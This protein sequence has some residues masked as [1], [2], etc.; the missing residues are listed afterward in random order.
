MTGNKRNAFTMIE[1]IFVIVILGILT[2]VALPKLSGTRDDAFTSTILAD[3]TT[4]ITDINAGYTAKGR[5]DKESPACHTAVKC[6]EFDL[7]AGDTSLTDGTY[8]VKH[9]HVDNIKCTPAQTMA[10]NKLLSS[11]DGITFKPGGSSISY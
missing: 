11:A 4:C 3:L 5:E 2:A 6:F 8:V 1:L 10:A 7:G 9:A